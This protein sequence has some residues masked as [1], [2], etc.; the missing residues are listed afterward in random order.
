MPRTV[1]VCCAALTTVG[2]QTKGIFSESAGADLVR[3]CRIR[4]S[5]D[6][7]RRDAAP[8]RQTLYGRG[9][10]DADVSAVVKGYARTQGAFR[11]DSV[12]LAS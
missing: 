8:K 5:S 2:P 6:P 9:V 10:V 12:K 7:L 4:C 1:L 11:I 3:L